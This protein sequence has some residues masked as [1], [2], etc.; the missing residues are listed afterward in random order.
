MQEVNDETGQ[1][2]YYWRPT[3]SRT[4]LGDAKGSDK[5]AAQ[6]RKRRSRHRERYETGSWRETLHAAP[7]PGFPLQGRRCR[8]RE[9]GRTAGHRLQI[10]PAARSRAGAT[11]QRAIAAGRGGIGTGADVT[12]PGAALD[13][14]QRI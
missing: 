10:P 13:T 1:N 12:S 2:F 6:G 8:R 11:V 14:H 3:V 4:R 9:A 7:R 5:S